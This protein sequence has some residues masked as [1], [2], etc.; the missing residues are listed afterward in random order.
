MQTLRQAQR[1]NGTCWSALSLGSLNV[2]LERALVPP[3]AGGQVRFLNYAG[4]YLVPGRLG[5][6]AVSAFEV[7]KSSHVYCRHSP[8]KTF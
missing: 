7:L 3:D 8:I 1:P 5:V 6:L 4:L 2:R